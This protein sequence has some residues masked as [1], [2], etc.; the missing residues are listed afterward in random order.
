M[1]IAAKAVALRRGAA[2][3]LHAPT[4]RAVVEN[5]KALAATLVERGLAIV[6]GGTDTHLM[7]VDLRP[8]E[9]HRPRRRDRR[10]SAPA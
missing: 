10:S 2:A 5:A 1:S 7:L 9:P 6:S 8:L 4:P 3:E